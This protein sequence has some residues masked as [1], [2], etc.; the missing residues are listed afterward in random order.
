MPAIIFINFCVGY[1]P[2]NDLTNVEQTSPIML[3]FINL[4]DAKSSKY[5]GTS[6]SQWE[7][8]PTSIDAILKSRGLPTKNIY[9]GVIKDEGIDPTFQPIEKLFA[10]SPKGDWSRMILNIAIKSDDESRELLL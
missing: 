3:Y 2:V 6:T 7:Q 10:K 8:T 9:V 1:G 4:F 5:I